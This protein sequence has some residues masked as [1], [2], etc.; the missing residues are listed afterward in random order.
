MQ[1]E[2]NAVGKRFLAIIRKEEFVIYRP[3]ET[4]I[5]ISLTVAY[6]D[7]FHHQNKTKTTTAYRLVSSFLLTSITDCVFLEGSKNIFPLLLA[8]ASQSFVD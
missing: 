2:T 5:D 3:N 6:H 8:A 4:G 7:K 1:R